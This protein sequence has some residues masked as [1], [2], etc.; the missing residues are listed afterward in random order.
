MSESSSKVKLKLLI[1]KQNQKV[2]FAEASKDFVD[3]LFSLM[4]LPLG[5]CVKLLTKNKMVG[6]IA[7]LHNSIKSLSKTYIQSSQNVES[8]LNPTPAM[9][10]F[11]NPLLLSNK[12]FVRMNKDVYMCPNQENNRYNDICDPYYGNQKVIY[13]PYVANHPNTVC[14]SCS[15]I[16]SYK[17]EFVESDC[18]EQTASG[19]GFVEGVVTY[20]VMDDLEVKAMSTISSIALINSFNVKDLGSLEEKV[21]YVDVKEG[22][23]I[24]E[25]SLQSKE[26]LTR[27]FLD[28]LQ[29]A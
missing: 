18:E 20:M 19:G 26:V 22:L 27:V 1:D 9:V 4:S 17:L 28:N 12:G 3:F 8:L 24:L 5:K 13:H 23:K 25:L 2:L 16:M 15:N 6:C 10:P 7:N 14:P 21:V 29:G 11:Q